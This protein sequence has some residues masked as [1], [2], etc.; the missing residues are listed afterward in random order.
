MIIHFSDGL[1]LIEMRFWEGLYSDYQNR[2]TYF[3]FFFFILNQ[4]NTHIFFL[5]R[6]HYNIVLALDAETDRFR[7]RQFVPLNPIQW[8]NVFAFQVQT[9]K[10]NYFFSKGSHFQR[11]LMFSSVYK[12]T[13]ISRIVVRKRLKNRKNRL[14]QYHI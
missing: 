2:Y 10:W 13:I 14:P 1:G 12:C 11:Y 5:N 7:S 6:R 4:L 9:R 8:Q 3:M